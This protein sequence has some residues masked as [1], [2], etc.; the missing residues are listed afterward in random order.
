MCDTIRKL[1]LAALDGRFLWDANEVAFKLNISADGV[2]L[3]HRQR[4]LQ[5]VLIGR[6]LRWKPRDVEMF[7]KDLDVGRDA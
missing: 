3:L 4:R 1:D 5:G 7:V 2:K 6:H